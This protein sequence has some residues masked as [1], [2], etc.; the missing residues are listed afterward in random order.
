[1][2]ESRTRS[3]VQSSAKAWQNLYNYYTITV[4]TTKNMRIR[5]EC[6]FHAPQIRPCLNPLHS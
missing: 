5:G 2:L 1:M 4:L 6:V 3:H